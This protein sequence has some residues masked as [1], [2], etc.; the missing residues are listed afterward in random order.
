MKVQIGNYGAETE[1]DVDMIAR[2]DEGRVIMVGSFDYGHAERITL[3]IDP[4][5]LARLATVA[6]TGK[7]EMKA[8]RAAA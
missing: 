2:L 7:P 3:W 6:L 1:L 5:E 4:D 8:A